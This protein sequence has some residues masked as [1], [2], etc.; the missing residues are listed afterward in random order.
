M[1]TGPLDGVRAGYI[2][3]TASPHKR[4]HVIAFAT[5]PPPSVDMRARRGSVVLRDGFCSVRR[6]QKSRGNS[7]RL[8]MGIQLA[9]GVLHTVT[10][11][12]CFMA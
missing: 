7:G 5:A 11:R 8:F 3:S 9:H 1:N 12:H 2:P 10:K 6:W 4:E